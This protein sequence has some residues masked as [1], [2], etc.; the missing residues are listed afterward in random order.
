MDRRRFLQAALATRGVLRSGQRQRETE[1]GFYRRLKGC[2]R[3]LEHP[4]W[5]VWCCAPFY[6]SAG[7]VHVFFC[8][9]P[10]DSKMAGWTSKAEV[11]HA[12]A[13]KP[14]GPYKVLGT[15]LRGRKEVGWADSIFNPTIHKIDGRFAIFF[16]GRDVKH[17]GL[18]Q[19]IGVAT[20]DSLEGPWRSAAAPIIPFSGKPGTWNC[21][22]AS[23]PA[24]LRHPNGQYWIY[25]KG[26]SDTTNPPLRTIGLAIADRLEGPYRDHPNNPLI[27]YIERGLDIEDPYAFHYGK[28]FY[29][30][31][32]DRMGVLESEPGRTRDAVGGMRPGLLYE[33][34]DGIHWGQPKIGYGAS[35]EYFKEP[36]NR[37]ERPQILWKNGEPDYLFMA[38]KGGKNGLSSGTVLKVMPGGKL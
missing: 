20:A 10:K 5:F 16:A 8:R 17:Q 30:L 3:I 13:D 34:E 7:K 32:E 33:S 35:D 18:N 25:Y 38:F 37:L 22:H 27:S 29:M 2:G 23:N 4:D 12:V 15:A 1:S 36:R 9:W 26:I 28:K 24:F 11:A 19:Q 6:D 31:T 21:L 14:E